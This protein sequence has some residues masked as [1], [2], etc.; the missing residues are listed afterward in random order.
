MMPNDEHELRQLLA[1][2]RAGTT[3]VDDAMRALRQRPA[4]GELGFATVDHDRARRCGFP[5]VVFCQGKRPED[6][7]AIAVE[8]LARADRLLMTRADEAHAAAVQ[9]RIPAAVW[10]ARARCIT[11][12]P[13]GSAVPGHGLVAVVCAGTADLPVAEEA[14]V[15][16]RAAGHRVETFTDVGVAGLHRLLAR[17]DAIRAANAIVAVAG[18][19]GALPSVLGGLVDKPVIAVPTSVGYGASFHGLAALLTM[20]NSCAAGVAV[21]NI[22]NGFGAGYL[23][24]LINL[25]TAAPS[26]PR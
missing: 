17:I 2:V 6:A 4:S 9:E 3:G 25:R 19:E 13:T 23:A 12:L 1:A 18:M 20:L 22:D 14:A 7:A 5:E 10:H 8:I 11:V 21:V 15:T 26:P 24:G 16:L